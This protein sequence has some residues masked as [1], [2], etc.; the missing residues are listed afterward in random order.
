M[1]LQDVEGKPAENGEI[2]G[3]IVHSRPVAV[4]VEVDVEHPVQLVL[5]GP[6]TA[7]NLQQSLGGH[8]LGEQ[9]VAQDRRIG[10]IALQLPARGDAADRNHTREAVEG[11]QAGYCA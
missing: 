2:L 5:D 10:T 3:S 4:L 7:R 6:M 9:V 8:G 11:S 1:G